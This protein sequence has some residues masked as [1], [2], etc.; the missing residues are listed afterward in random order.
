M[1]ESL[2]PVEGQREGRGAGGGERIPS[3]FRD[4]SERPDERLEPM[5]L[6]ITP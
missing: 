5:N 4:L 2:Q 6:E 3:R 1:R